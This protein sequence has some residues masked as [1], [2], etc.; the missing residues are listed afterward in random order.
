MSLMGQ[1]QTSTAVRA[2]SAKPLMADSTPTLSDVADVPLSD[3]AA[4]MTNIEFEGC[5]LLRLMAS[6]T[7]RHWIP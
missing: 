3:I 7:I 2:T 5:A 4:I 6:L 1:T